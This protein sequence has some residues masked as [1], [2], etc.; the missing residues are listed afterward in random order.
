MI[1]SIH[2]QYEKV[3]SM[4]LAIIVA[5]S[6]NRVIGRA[7]GLP[8]HLPKDLQYFKRVTLGK[9]IIMGRKTFES[10][11][12]ALPGRVNIVVSR[13]RQYTAPGVVHAL[14]L[15]A[16]IE[17]AQGVCAQSSVAEVMIIGGA[18]IYSQALEMADV[19]YV[20][21]VQ[22]DIEGDAH[23]PEINHSLYRQTYKEDHGAD[24]QNPYPYSFITYQKICQ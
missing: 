5:Q 19:L 24:E 16:A 18:Q 10:I 11:G 7:N 12:R 1:K 13:N 4:K 15:E 22:A 17:V 6:Q 8:W 3:K 23:F 2:L 14:T 9:P 21:S 20:T